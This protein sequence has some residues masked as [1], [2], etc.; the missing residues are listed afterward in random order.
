M[1]TVYAPSRMGVLNMLTL[2]VFGS[3]SARQFLEQSK[4]LF[5][6]KRDKKRPLAA[7][8]ARAKTVVC[9]AVDCGGARACTAAAQPPP[10]TTER[11]RNTSSAKMRGAM[12]RAD[13]A[14]CKNAKLQ[15][16]RQEEERGFDERPCDK[17]LSRCNPEL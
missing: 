4:L 9:V 14:L 10:V 12:R 11:G 1:R 6:A 3:A 8:G 5:R 2:R 13:R 7:H 17:D 15:E 16:Q